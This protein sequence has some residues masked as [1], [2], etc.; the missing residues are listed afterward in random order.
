MVYCEQLKEAPLVY[1]K[2]STNGVVRVHLKSLGSI[3]QLSLNI[4]G[5]YKI[6]NNYYNN[7]IIDVYINDSNSISLKT[8]SGLVKSYNEIYLVRESISNNNYLI[9][10]RCLFS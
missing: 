2:S 8:K 5:K 4:N 6:N 9:A 7:E 1:M 10:I 3:N